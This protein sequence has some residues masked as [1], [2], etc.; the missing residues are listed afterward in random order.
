MVAGERRRAGAG[1]RL[2][3][4]ADRARLVLCYAGFGFGYIIPATFVPAMAKNII[5]DPAVFGWAWPIFGA[6]AALST[7]FAAGHGNRRIW[8]IAALAMAAGVAAPLVI[9]GAAGILAS[10]FLVGG[11]F[12]VITMAGMQEARELAGPD[13]PALMAAMTAAFAAGQIAGPL[14]VSYLVQRSGFATAL[15][16]AA[17]VLVLSAITLAL[18]PKEKP[19]PT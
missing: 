19:C 17:A 6:T 13:A 18:G 1:A 8:T 4:T 5:E 2:I 16:I 14:L 9:P 12:M 15:A 10:A 7:L 11:T 3:W